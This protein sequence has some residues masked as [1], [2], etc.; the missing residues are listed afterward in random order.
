MLKRYGPRTL[1]FM[2]LAT[3]SSSFA[4]VPAQTTANRNQPAIVFAVTEEDGNFNLDAV[5]AVSGKLLRAPFSEDKEAQQ[6]AFA[7]QYFAAGKNYRLLFGGGEVGSVTLKGWSR[8]CNSVHA[9]ASGSTPVHLTGQVKGLATSSDSIGKRA[10]ARRAPTAAEREAVMALVK[11]IYA[12]HEVSPSLY[13]AL[14]VTNLTATDLDGDGK[15]EMIGSFTLATKAKLERDL[16][17]IAKPKGAA[18]RAEFANFQTYQPPAEGFLSSIDFVDQL[19][20]DGDGIGEVFAVQGG[21]DAY[22]YVIYKKRA[23]RW[24]KVYSGMGDAC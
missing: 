24:L 10:P 2:L 15:Y 21:F 14:G 20:L 9:E 11:Q 22:G 17:L 19:D 12:Q 1:A 6:D 8:G 13:R 3:L 23:G 7:K 5:V 18:M 16:F 4:P